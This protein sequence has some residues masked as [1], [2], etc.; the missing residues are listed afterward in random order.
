MALNI[1]NR[2]VEKLAETVAAMTG[3]S[4]TQA[5]RKALEERKERLSFHVVRRDRCDE[6]RAFMDREVWPVVP[7]KELGK[8]FS[9]KKR[10]QILGYGPEGV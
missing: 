5:I 1:K 9:R 3:E 2:D 10:E 4:K 8:S 6:L 7:R